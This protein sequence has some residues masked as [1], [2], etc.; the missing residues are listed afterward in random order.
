MK[1]RLNQKNPEKTASVSNLRKPTL[2]EE[3][4]PTLKEK[5][6][7]FFRSSKKNKKAN[8]ETREELK[9]KDEL[10]EEGKPLYL[11]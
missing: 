11:R 7:N 2:E 8:P 9:R 4:K 1:L 3:R 6:F 10:L 5:I